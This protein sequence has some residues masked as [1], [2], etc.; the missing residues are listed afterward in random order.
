M[1]HWRMRV[2][3]RLLLVV[4]T[5]LRAGAMAQFELRL[6][7]EDAE[8]VMLEFRTSQRGDVALLQGKLERWRWSDEMMFLQVLGARE[9]GPGEVWSLPLVRLLDVPPGTYEA[10]ATV[11]SEPAPPSARLQV[12]VE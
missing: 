9:L 2:P 8:P 11:S 4:E 3:I 10:V 5:P 7:N 1:H 12:V 6:T